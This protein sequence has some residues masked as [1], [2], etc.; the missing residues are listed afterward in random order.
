[1]TS[2]Y[3]LDGLGSN[4]Y[5]VTRLAKALADFDIHLVY[6]PL[7]GHPDNLSLH[8]EQL[9]DFLAWFEGQ[10]VEEKAIL[11]GYSLGA[12]F[13]TYL[14]EASSK[15][16]KLIL[17]DG[18]FWQFDDYP[19]SQELEESRAY[20]ASQVTEN[21]SVVI[22]EEVNS[23]FWDADLEQAIHYAYE[24][25]DNQYRLALNT[26]AI[27]SLLTMRRDCQG[28]L[29][30]E[31]VMPPILLIVSGQP[32]EVFEQKKTLISGIHRGQLRLSYLMEAS[33]QLYLEYPKE[34]AEQIKAFI[35]P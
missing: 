19:L 11:M 5:Y 10:V 18:G 17:L 35:A 14:A 4:R 30:S 33:H 2:V 7:P 28:I 16:E 31:A 15:V 22:A 24:K 29:A 3:F 34:I 27:L 9:D 21:I 25:I 26:E 6:L 20:I 32:R 13:A 23:P 8:L 12:D 1:M